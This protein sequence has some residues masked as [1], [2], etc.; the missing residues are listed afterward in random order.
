VNDNGHEGAESRKD[1]CSIP[2]TPAEQERGA[3]LRRFSFWVLVAVALIATAGSPVFWCLWWATARTCYRTYFARDEISILLNPGGAAGWQS[4]FSGLDISSFSALI[5]ALTCTLAAYDGVKNTIRRRYMDGKAYCNRAY[6][7]FLFSPKFGPLCIR[8]GLLGTLASFLLAAIS[9]LSAAT[10]GGSDS[11]TRT[12]E[13]RTQEVVAEASPGEANSSSGAADAVTASVGQPQA[14]ATGQLSGQIF[15]L[16]C[17]SLVSTFT[18]CFVA[19]VVVPPLNWLN[20]HA[21]GLCQRTPIDEDAVTEEFLR[22]IDR[23]CTE[24]DKFRAVV[25]GVAAAANGMQ[26]FRAS[27]DDAGHKF[28]IMIGR[29]G[30]AAKLSEASNRLLTQAADT[31]GTAAVQNARVPE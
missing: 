31:L 14:T 7:G 22:Q 23:T 25:D 6:D 21:I 28:D 12:L 2:L 9:Q 17:A 18:G 19:Y 29:L 4:Y 30:T 10:Q 5:L 24:L 15:L 26:G 13:Q 3:V 16:L 1:S 20:D 27:V 11:E 8:L